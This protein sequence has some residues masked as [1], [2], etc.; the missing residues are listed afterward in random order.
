MIDFNKLVSN[1]LHKEI[2]EKQT[3][4]YYPSEAGNCIRKVW[5]SYKI[6][7]ETHDEL[8]KIFEVGN[9]FHD[10]VVDV[11]KSEKNPDV[12]LLESEMPLQLQL[13]DVVISGRV[14]DIILLKV[15]G[16]KIIVEVKSTSSLEYAKPS[17]SYVMQLQLYMHSLKVDKGMI[18]FIEKNTMQCKWFNLSYNKDIV[19]KAIERI[20]KLHES[21]VKNKMP[22]PEARARAEMSWMC[23]KCNY[24][25]E[26]ERGMV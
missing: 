6:P 2:R 9:M 22:E 15:S 14:D 16:E 20:K 10:F 8:M 5:F 25:E 17:E 19:N 12:E 13:D 24:K 4:R 7:K 26:C 21:L 11:I 3:G 18:L 1:F 23:K